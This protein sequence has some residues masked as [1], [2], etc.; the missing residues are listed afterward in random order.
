MLKA[1]LMDKLGK[2]GFFVA[3]FERSPVSQHT[4]V[5]KD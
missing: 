2:A 4:W 1:A 5:K 3:V